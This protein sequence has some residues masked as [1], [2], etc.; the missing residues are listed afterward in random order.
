MINLPCT[1]FWMYYTVETIVRYRFDVNKM[2]F[3]AY[4]FNFNKKLFKNILQKL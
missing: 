1:D 4:S 2:K 3:L